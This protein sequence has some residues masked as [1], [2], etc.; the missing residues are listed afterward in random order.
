MIITLLFSGIIY[1]NVNQ[2]YTR[3]EKFEKLRQEERELLTVTL[4]TYKIKLTPEDNI[5]QKRFMKRFDSEMI[6]QFRMRLLVTLAGIDSLILLVAGFAGYFLA[7]RTLLPIK[8][9]MDE[10]NRFVTDASHEIRTPLT[11]IKSSIEVNLRNKKLTLLDAKKI[12]QSNLEEVN[13]LQVLSDNLI[14]LTQYPNRATQS[15]TAVDIKDIS[16]EA[17][18]KVSKLATHKKIKIQNNIPSIHIHGNKQLLTE[19]LV[20]ILDNAIKY[21]Y[22]RSIVRLT[23]VHNDGKI[24][25]RIAD[26]GVGI[27]EKDIPYIFDR[28][29]RVDKA[30]TKNNSS[31]Y[32]LG[33]SIAKH[34][35]KVHQG[36][37]S[38]KSNLQKGTTFFITLLKSHKI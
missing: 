38:V 2:E 10:Q 31:G 23:S 7:G 9:M 29:Y 19:L 36:T 8:K 13:N 15:F 12:L 14:Q 16:D 30:R 26:E 17:I 6:Q 21:S 27:D 22:E 28:F 18:K 35:V 24:T 32:G 25:L 5:P 20:I 37:I 33:L 1:T 11:S 4:N 3:I 34:I